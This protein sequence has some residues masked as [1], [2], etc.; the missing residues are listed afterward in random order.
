MNCGH[1]KSPL[2][3]V[4]LNVDPLELK[5]NE[6]MLSFE[7]A[8]LKAQEN[9]SPYFVV[10]AAKLS[11]R[12]WVVLD[13]N[14]ISKEEMA[15]IETCLPFVE[16]IKYCAYR[17]FN[18]DN[19]QIG[20]KPEKTVFKNE[21]IQ[22]FRKGEQGLIGTN[23]EASDAFRVAQLNIALTFLPK[24]VSID[25]IEGVRWAWSASKSQQSEIQK[26]AFTLIGRYFYKL[27]K[28]AAREN[29]KIFLYRKSLVWLIKGV[30]L[31]GDLTSQLIEKI[32]KTLLSLESLSN[33]IASK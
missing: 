19:F 25:Q 27:A 23:F 32:Q 7:E 29:Y 2:P 18:F 33:N 10:T 11:K 9:F 22:S 3:M 6:L 1:I 20:R 5:D 30:C 4:F 13:A 8:F 17:C 24:D 12:D 14:K 15:D 26:S 31:D 21:K 28:N 16:E